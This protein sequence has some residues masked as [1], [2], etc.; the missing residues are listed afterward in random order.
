MPVR[1][2][3]AGRGLSAQ[4]VPAAVAVSVRGPKDVVEG[5]RPDSV[6]AFVD[7]AG[8]G[9]GRYNLSVR[10]EPAQE[11]VVVRS[12]PTIVQVRIK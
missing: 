2:R 8:L 6:G 5:L 11:F 4:V 9:P 10:L 1:V 3:N 12:E 7:L